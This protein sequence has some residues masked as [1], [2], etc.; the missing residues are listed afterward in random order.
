MR[1]DCISGINRFAWLGIVVRKRF[2][3]ANSRKQ[4][5]MKWLMERSFIVLFGC[6]GTNKRAKNQ[7]YL[8]FSEREY[9]KR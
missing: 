9:L 2:R 7:I 4:N 6:K 3:V 8:D 5:E 1:D